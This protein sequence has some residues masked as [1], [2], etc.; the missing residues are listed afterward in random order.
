[1]LADQ[2]GIDPRALEL[3]NKVA[4]G[5]ADPQEREEWAQLLAT[6]P[7]LGPEFEAIQRV[8]KQIDALPLVDAPAT[9][10]P[11]ILQAL[12]QGHPSPAVPLA[13]P[14]AHRSPTFKHWQRP[15]LAWAAGIA[16]IVGSAYFLDRHDWS[17]AHGLDPSDV[18]GSMVAS[19]NHS[20]PV[21]QS[22]EPPVPGTGL[23]LILRRDGNRFA[24]ESQSIGAGDPG[25]TELRWDP[26]ALECVA[27][28]P[29]GED[30]EALNRSGSVRLNPAREGGPGSLQPV[31][32]LRPRAGFN[33]PQEVILLAGGREYHRATISTK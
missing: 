16:L 5:T 10:K 20:W 23:K 14:V 27:V 2:K 11:D 4:D 24:V 26:R 33:K 17:G 30:L 28:E 13:S 15:A 21:V 7:S 12:R 22:H 32:I 18:S 3:L 19:N 1:M 31:I 8:V 9:M 25:P 29:S 6:T